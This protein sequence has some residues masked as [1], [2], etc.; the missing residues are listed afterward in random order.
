MSLRVGHGVD[1]HRLV[2]GRPLMLGCIHVPHDRGL[3]GHSDG[4]AVVHALC[5]ALLG[6][7]G[8]GDIGRHFPSGD[9]RWTNTAGIEFLGTVAT[10]L[11]DHGARVLSAQV[12]AIA[13]EPRLADYLNEMRAACA[14][15]L[16]MDVAAMAISATTTDG[17][18]FA[19]RT[20][21]I[22]TSAVA[23]VEVG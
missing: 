6:A 1:A 8:L 15:A 2:A 22:A 12:V 9:P 16:G 13:E 4:D 23:L 10:M 18:G 17:M 21:G 11:R 19:G 20:D 5:D 14:Q 3:L 7:A